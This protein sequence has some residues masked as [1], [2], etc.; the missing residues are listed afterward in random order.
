MNVKELDP[1]SSP[2]ADFGA[3]LRSARE[4]RGW[5]QEQLSER[6]AYAASHISAVETGRKIPTLR[7]ARSADKALGAGEEFERACLKLRSGGLLEGFPQF[8]M[9]EAKAAEIRLFEVGLIPGLLQTR[10]YATVIARSELR[11]GSISD[12]QAEERIELLAERQATL[13]RTP[14]PHVFAVLD[15]SC[16]RRSLGG[17]AVMAAQ[18][19]RLLEFAELPDTSL[20]VAPFG[21]G[22]RRSF[23]LPIYILTLQDRSL[24]SY[25]ESAHRGSLERDKTFVLPLLRAYHQLQAEALS[26]TESVAMIRELRKGTT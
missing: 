23:D 10:E 9:H 8:L 1:D 26:P 7:F 14:P 13:T 17:P 24:V 16:L 3:R 19:E 22:E 11:R 12:E 4:E 6:M 5:T 15:E 18:L 2:Q 25:A 21:I 20:Q